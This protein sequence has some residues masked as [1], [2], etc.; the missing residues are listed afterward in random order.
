MKI[1]HGKNLR[2]GR[3]SETER[4]YL[5]T[6]VTRNRRQLLRDWRIGRLLV[7]QLR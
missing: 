1:H 4:P 2:I 7:A 3:V 5:I 6:T